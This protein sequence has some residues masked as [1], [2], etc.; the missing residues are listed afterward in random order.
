MNRIN[1]LKLRPQDEYSEQAFR[2]GVNEGL[3]ETLFSPQDTWLYGASGLG[4]THLAHILVDRIDNSL[5]VD[6]ISYRLHGIEHFELVVLDSIEIWLGSKEEEK[7]IF[8]LYE[9]LQ[10]LGNR[11]VITA[12][13]SVIE[14][15]FRF[16]DL[17][18]RL[19]TFQPYQ[20]QPLRDHEK[21]L[22]V[23]QLARTRGFDLS[24]EVLQFIFKYVGRS[25]TMLVHLLDTFEN[26][27]ITHDR[28]ITIPFVKKVLDL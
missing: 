2:V 1:S 10:R 22:L 8:E 11:L 21:L 28:R 18:S 7:R 25:Q 13:K 19:A 12:R 16:I 26:E 9:R 24:D 6:E 23:Q 3:F 4:K 20:L 14:Y 27:S 15:E 5:L 17:R